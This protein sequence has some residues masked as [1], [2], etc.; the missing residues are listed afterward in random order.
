MLSV[1]S[2]VVR[3]L[4]EGHPQLQS[5]YYWQDNAGCY[6][7]GTTIVEA[8]LVGQQHG[9]S[10][11]RMDFCDSQAGKGACDRKAATIKSHMKIFLN[12]ENNI[13]SAE[14][15]K[16]AI[17]SSGGVNVTV[18]GPPEVSTFS[19][20]RL[21]GVS[22][23]SNIEYSEEGLRVWKAYK[24]GPGKLIQWEKLDVQPNAEIPRLSAIDCGTCGEKAQF[25]TITS[26]EAKIPP[27]Q[28]NSTS[29]SD[30]PSSDK[31]SSDESNVGLF[32]LS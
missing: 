31:S 8:K 19:T 15:M 29:P 10:V 26:K 22:T 16:N 7:C 2:D 13:E 14:E 28:A 9:V 27:K 17:L 6:H 32:F 11:R 24:I 23:I 21:E 4:R 20:V 18:S 25:K 1:M 5:I 3:Q 12:S 30:S